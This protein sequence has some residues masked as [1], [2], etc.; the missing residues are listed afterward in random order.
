M[1]KDNNVNYNTDQSNV[2]SFK[3]FAPD[4]EKKSLEDDKRNYL[5]N[6]D[7]KYNLP[8]KKRL[9]YNK[10]TKTW[11]DLSKKEVKDKLKALEKIKIKSFDEVINE[12]EYAFGTKQLNSETFLLDLEKDIL[13][14]KSEL[15]KVMPS[16]QG[17]PHVKNTLN[18]INIHFEEMLVLIK[19]RHEQY[20]LN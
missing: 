16:V 14:H 8:N 7:E 9:R 13:K 18:E 10:V 11:Q 6:D 15:N 17:N 1:R 19:N 20:K 4:K 3:D 5:K 2:D 12:D